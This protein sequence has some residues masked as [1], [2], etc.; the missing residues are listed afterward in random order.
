MLGLPEIVVVVVTSTQPKYTIDSGREKREGDLGAE[1]MSHGTRD[2]ILPPS[3]LLS[4]F[5]LCFLWISFF[6]RKMVISSGTKNCIVYL[7]TFIR[8]LFYYVTRLSY[9][10]FHYKE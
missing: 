9:S 2:V 6:Y 10:F 5:F 7:S 8:I 4:L 1:D 3:S